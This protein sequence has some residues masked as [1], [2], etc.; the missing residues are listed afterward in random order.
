M[1]FRYH[2][3]EMR[4]ELENLREILQAQ[5]TSEEQK[6]YQQQLQG[7][8]E[9]KTLCIRFFITIL[10]KK[11]GFFI[12][13]SSIVTTEVSLLRKQLTEALASILQVKQEKEKVEAKAGVLSQSVAKLQAKLDDNES[14]VA[15]L[16]ENIQ[17]LQLQLSQQ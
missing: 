15:S 4:K 13:Y 6:M 2:S 12:F 10:Y 3:Q 5:G 14:L 9:T 17:D 8:Q 1:F 16:R 7:L 11:L